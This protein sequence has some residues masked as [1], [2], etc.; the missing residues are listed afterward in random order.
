MRLLI[1]GWQGQVAR[2]LLE[3]APARA[4]VTACAAGRPAL[5]ICEI[6]AIERALMQVRPDVVINTAAWTDVDGAESDPARAFAFNR[7]G[8]RLLAEMAARR[9]AAIIHVSTDY[10]FD[11]TGAR[12]YRETDPTHPATVYGRSKLDGE[13]AV[14]AANTRHV[15]LR[16]SWV[17]SPWGRNF[18][19]AVAARVRAG[20]PLRVVADRHGSPTYAPHLAAVILDIAA[21]LA[22]GTDDAMH[23][24]YHAAGRDEASW[25]DLA[26]GIAGHLRPEGFSI[27]RIG[28]DEDARARGTR[29]PRPA[30]A[31][32]DSSK[33]GDAFGFSLPSWRDGLAG[34]LARLS[35][36]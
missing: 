19:S 11:G 15:I 7:D 33:L 30:Y 31:V 27:E 32:L 18:V 23:G 17:Y 2:A 36:A 10:V 26:R 13:A 8:P 5:N 20:S 34:C 24:T 14:R 1:A 6:G 25:Y 29:A 28:S 9:G 3:Q 35:A 12:P 16:T 4:D 21:R 22:A